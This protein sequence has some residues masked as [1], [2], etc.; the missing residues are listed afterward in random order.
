MDQGARD[1]VKDAQGT[2][3]PGLGDP[4]DAGVREKVKGVPVGGVVGDCQ[5]SRVL[6]CRGLRGTKRHCCPAAGPMGAGGSEGWAWLRVQ[7]P[8]EDSALRVGG[9]QQCQTYVLLRD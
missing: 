7:K 6:S 1:D 5:V 4:L 8:R 3:S 2:M 9:E